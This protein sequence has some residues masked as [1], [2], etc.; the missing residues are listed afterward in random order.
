ML[1]WK[2]P[3]TWIMLVALI[4]CVVAIVF[5]ATNPRNDTE[6]NSMVVW[7]TKRE[8]PE[9]VVDIVND[10]V[11]QQV[12]YYNDLGS[13]E[14]AIGG[15][16]SILEAWIWWNR[17]AKQRYGRT[18]MPSARRPLSVSLRMRKKNTLCVI[19]TTEV[20]PGLQAG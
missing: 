19:H 16:Y 9:A 1:N 3:K 13:G 7:E 17:S 10:Y 12:A 18:F 14:N 5:C 8:Y 15:E 11:M 2:K 20:W 6:E 4:A